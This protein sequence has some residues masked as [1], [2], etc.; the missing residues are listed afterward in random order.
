MSVR[1][2]CCGTM[3][4]VLLFVMI[5]AGI[6]S[7]SIAVAQDVV[8][9]RAWGPEQATGEPDT[10]EA[11]DFQTAWASLSSDGSEEWLVCEYDAAYTLK[12]VSVY[13]NLSPGSLYKVTAFNSDGDEVLAWEGE[14]PTPRDKPKGI[15]VIP[16]KLDF[17]VQKIKL[18]LDSPAVSGWNEID[19]VGIEDA[20]GNKHWAQTV[21]ASSTYATPNTV[22]TGKRSYGSEQAA[23]P[24]DTEAAGDYATAWAS[25]TADG[26]AEWLICH[27]EQAAQPAEI[28]VYENFNPGAVTKITVFDQDDKETLA[29]EGV[30]PTPR[31]QQRGVSVFPV[32]LDFAF[33]KIK[34]YLDSPNVAGWN[35]IDAVGLRDSEGETQWAARVDA[36]TI[37]G[38]TQI[39]V[40][41]PAPPVPDVLEQLRQEVSQLRAD[42]DELKELRAEIQELKQLLRE[43]KEP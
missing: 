27:Y 26:Q 38:V 24:P 35:E 20:A 21:L 28:V 12:S 5:A 42:L 25:A 2:K 40:P 31:D 9:K 11:G 14:D 34:V 36:S 13:E 7:L 29:W 17:K 23:G 4:F 16:V 33:S 37:Y 22:E 19:A 8:A 10:P 30:D 6:S 32:K 43:R 41:E 39:T 3:F 1:R 18:Y 15:S